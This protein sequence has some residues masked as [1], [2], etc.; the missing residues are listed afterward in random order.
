MWKWEGE[1]EAEGVRCSLGRLSRYPLIENVR[2]SVPFGV[3]KIVRR[4]KQ[5]LD[6]CAFGS[7]MRN[8]RL[9]MLFTFMLCSNY[10]M[11]IVPNHVVKIVVR[12]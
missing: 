2:H 1:G 11:T 6:F 10:Q 4:N 8:D 9:T 3:E 5:S 12:V 7:M